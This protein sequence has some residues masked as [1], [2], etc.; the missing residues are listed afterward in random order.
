MNLNSPNLL[1]DPYLLFANWF[2]VAME[3]I[4]IDPNAVVL[5]TVGQSMQPSSRIV[6]L[7]EY[8]SVCDGF[9]FYTNYN[10]RKGKE[11]YSNTKA[12][13]LFYWNILHRQIRI[14]GKIT[15]V[16]LEVSNSYFVSRPRLSKI[17][18][19]ISNQ[20]AKISSREELQK[21]FE[22]YEKL[23]VGKNLQRPEHWGGYILK[24]HYFEFWQAGENRLHD[25]ISYS[26][27]KSDSKD[28]E[29]YRLSP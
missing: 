15:K 4:A 29:Q 3:S 6:L 27:K 23:H 10:S 16:S 28:W 14:E 12:C 8:G 24:P 17:G 7:K 9:I 13:M 22:M 5:S 2:E 26:R 1:K 20:S 21:S 11:L 25:R 19:I 18:A